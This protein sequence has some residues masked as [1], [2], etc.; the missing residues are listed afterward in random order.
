M[1]HFPVFANRPRRA[2]LICAASIA[3]F[4]ACHLPSASAATVTWTGAGGD[5]N[6]T[7]AANW[8]GTAPVAGDTLAFD[9][10]TQLL[11][12]NDFGAATT[13]LGINFNATAGSFV[14]SGS[15]V[16][17]T[18][19]IVDNSLSTE[20]I[21]LNLIFAA[22]RTLSAVTG[23]ILQ[24]GG[25][26]GFVSGAGGITKTGGGTVICNGSGTNVNTYTGATTLSAGTLSLDFTNLTTPTNLIN[27]GSAL[28]MGGGTLSVVGKAGAATSQTFAA[29][30]FTGGP[31]VISAT[32]GTGGTTTLSL[33]AIT[34]TAPGATVMYVGPATI[35]G[36]GNVAATGTI[37]TTTAG[38]GF[39]GNMGAF[40]V[41]KI[42]GYATVGLYDWA[43]T[44]T[45]AGGVGASPYTIIGGSQVAG[46]YQTAGITTAGNYDVTPGGVNAIGNA[47]G[48]NTLRFNNPGAL[49]INSTAF[50]SQNLQGILVTPNIGAN[51]ASYTGNT[52]E[53]VRSTSGGNCYG[54][55]WQNNTLGYFNMSV[56]LGPGRQ[57]SQQNGLVQAGLGTV[58]YSGAND[59][60]LPTYL[61][62]GFSVISA[63]N[64]FGRV[65]NGSAINLNGGTVVGKATF[66]LDNGGANKR[67]V[68]LLGN[69]G[70]LAATTGFTMT[71]DGV[72]SGAAGTGALV[73]GIPASAANGNT[74]GL[75]PGSGAG[76][77]NA[78]AVNAA[79]IVALTG[80]NTYTGGTIVKSGTVQIN[81]LNALGGANYNGLILD[82]GGLQYAATLGNGG[83]DVTAGAGVT[84]RAGG[85]AIDVVANNVTLASPITG[86]GA[87][88]TR[89][90][91]GV[92]TLSGP[93]TYGGATTIAS[94][95]LAVT[96]VTGSATG[97]GAVTQSGGTL[98]GAG[99]IAGTVTVTGGALMPGTVTAGRAGTGVL[100]LGNLTLS[101]GAAINYGLNGTPTNNYLTT[102][103]L[104]LPGAGTVT[105]N[106]YQPNTASTFAA[107]GTYDLFQYTTLVAPNALG[108]YFAIGTPI[109]GFTASYGTSGGFLQLTLAAAGVAGSWTNGNATGNWSEAGNWS[110]GVPSLPGSSA[111]FAAAPG[112]VTL[113][114]NKTVGGLT[115]NNAAAY[116]IVGA[117]T[118]TLDN[119]GSG[120]VIAVTTGAHVIQTAVAFNDN[121]TVTPAGG[122]QLTVSGNITQASGTRS[123][124][125]TGT[126][127]LVLSGSNSYSGGTAVSNG[128]LNFNG[129]AALG[130]GTA[131]DLGSAA[132]N[133]T[134]KYASLNTADISSLTVSLNA[135]GATIDTNGNDVTYANAIGN[136][137]AGGLTKIGSGTLTLAGAN[138]YTGVTV[139]NAGAL[140]INGNASL[141]A[142]ATGAALT[143]NG[144]TL[145][146]TATFGLFNGAAGT[147][148]RAI[149]LGAGGGT[150]APAVGTALTVTGP[151]TGGH[152][153]KLDSG[154]LTILTPVAGQNTFNG[155]TL[156]SAGTILLGDINA[157]GTGLGTGAITLNG[158]TLSLRYQNGASGAQQGGLA[159]NIV[160]DS[161]FTGTLITATRQDIAGSLT[162]NGTFNYQTDYVR[163]N[164]TGNWSAFTGQINVLPNTNGGD[165]RINNFNGFGTARINLANGA[166]MSVLAN[167]GAGG[168]TLTVG[169][170][171]GGA[172]S[173]LGGGPTP[174]RLLTWS[175]GGA[176]TNAQFD[177]TIRD[178][179][180]NNSGVG[181]TAITKVG[182]GT[183]TLTGTNTYTGPTIVD[184]GTLAIAGGTSGTA[185][186]NILVAPANADTAT[187]SIATGAT[188][189][190]A[191][192]LIG[193]N[194]GATTGGNGAV[195]Q[196]GGTINSATYFSV[197]EFGIGAFNM[198]G[199]ILN[200]NSAGGTNMEVATFA[201]SSGT[202]AISGASQVNLLNNASLN[203][204]AQTTIG[205]G[206]V[207]QSGG[208]VIFYSDAGVTAG[209]TGT[210]TLGALGT[211]T[212][213]YNLDGGA[214]R[215]P[216]VI[217]NTGTAVFNFNGGTLTALGDTAFFMQGLTAANVR[218]GG[219]RINTNGFNVTVGQALPH[220]AIGGDNAVDGGLTKT[221]NGILTLSG[222]NPFTG[223]A[224]VTLGTVIAA[225]NLPL[226]HGTTGAGLLLNP[227]VATTATVKFTSAAPV[228]A[229]LS[230]TGA[231]VS[232]IVLGD[233]LAGTPT[234]LTVGGNGTSTVYSGGISDGSGTNPLAVGTVTKAGA[235]TLT[236]S[237]TQTY[238][239]L[240]ANG[241]VTNLNS[242]LGTGTSTINANAAVNINASQTLAALI[243]ADGVEVT[244][245]DGLP[246]DGG[247]DKGAAFGGGTAAVPEPGSA[248]LL[249][250]GALGFLSRQKRGAAARSARPA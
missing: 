23:G 1:K 4:A 138:T 145:S 36:A 239:T 122:T 213:T 150:F 56:A 194:A 162:G 196:T 31:N 204:G 243:I 102:G 211:G 190:S 101:G 158:G 235:G 189:N 212:Y 172:T 25:A 146:S 186:A 148:D 20:T 156:I 43:S 205:N 228:I 73:I 132:T 200:V 135:G 71:V 52:L 209:G 230:N 99:S 113:D 136:G 154:Q 185:A 97:A 94:G 176:G 112:T 62:G 192:F 105:L 198:S 46:F 137:G 84:L 143:L 140:S 13:F 177:G 142:A 127:T 236:L 201:A 74:A 109:T 103:I 199:G 2:P 63:N 32:D 241:G 58:V 38:A 242:A 170:L 111:T 80:A 29:T 171:S 234:V 125:K 141:G 44:A 126:G 210:L 220:S 92:L 69:G 15:S 70:G 16:N 182:A 134:L 152:L 227:A 57:A 76:T 129:L 247:P 42:G 21:N 244:F 60:E 78:T 153:T 64:G 79:G 114:A 118:L 206:T 207:T 226:G 37:T 115:F 229:S 224:T 91:S 27:S 130:S 75:L 164:Q 223:A 87:L 22:T 68:T 217:H 67:P 202:V 5:A 240:N 144:G 187:L 95:T 65:A 120:A 248:G 10:V 163:V 128:V 180:T 96:N 231:G 168:L 222:L 123:L 51:N 195:T 178:G 174:G 232:S 173:F 3:L 81:G 41:G 14:L 89:G 191:L 131:L 155:G 24:I 18:G 39:L 238:K 59:Y 121:V 11:D 9:G 17:S 35:S 214:L 124:T 147:N 246:F 82:G 119:T 181:N 53:F 86:T 72:V 19:G 66:T 249:L 237:G 8:G 216:S 221:G 83:N 110:G 77:A 88:T 106:L 159:N 218:N 55:I 47:S 165:F 107:T 215:V 151:V 108:T 30:T 183:W 225:S 233:A 100:A 45:T 7:T 33:G 203:M 219:A 104:T 245:G 133:G 54:V 117:N 184:A 157:V 167:F 48:A 161:G 26:S 193:S 98:T 40:G 149:S 139:V 12:T 61:N 169:E 160:V 28:V 85:G 90:T 175:V 166:N 93:S 6:W 250:A 208:T 179:G 188:L 116:A 50:T 49:N 197:G 34:A